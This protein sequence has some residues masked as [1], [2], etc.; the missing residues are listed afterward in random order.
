MVKTIA[1][2]RSPIL[3]ESCSQ[4]VKEWFAVNNLMLNAD[5]SD[6]MLF[7]PVARRRSYFRR[8]PIAHGSNQVTRELSWTVVWVVLLML[9]L[10]ARLVTTT[11]GPYDTYAII[12]THDVANTLACSI[13]GTH[14]DYCNSI[15]YGAS[16]SSITKLQRLQNLLA[17]VVLQQTRR[18]H[19]KPLLR[20][21]SFT[22][23]PSNIGWLKPG[24]HVKWNWNKTDTKLKQN[25][26]I[27][28]SFQPLAH[29]KRNWNKTAEAV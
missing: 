26:C 5:K 29:V 22:G 8:E 11:Y 21:L 24:A 7:S 25:S 2:Q 10:C 15:L 13:V 20:S 3:Y 14:I 27:S 4:T 17:R 9:K 19:A 28:V 23:Y 16:T 12:L 1:D 18:T 6:V